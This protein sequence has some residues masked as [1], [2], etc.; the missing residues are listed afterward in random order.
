MARREYLVIAKPRK[1]YAA[2]RG[3]FILPCVAESVQG[4]LLQLYVQPMWHMYGSMYK[5]PKA[6]RGAKGVLLHFCN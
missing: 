3:M 1:R 2:S 5:T 6:I 4:A